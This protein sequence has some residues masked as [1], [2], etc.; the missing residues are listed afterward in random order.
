MAQKTNYFMSQLGKGSTHNI[1]RL[2]FVL[3]LGITG[4]WAVLAY[5]SSAYNQDTGNQ[6]SEVAANS[7]LL[8]SGGLDTLAQSTGQ[9]ERLEAEIISFRPYGFEPAEITRQHGRFLLAV[10]N[11]S[12][13]P[14]VEFQ[15]HRL[16]GEKLR[17]LRMT[18]GR[19]KLNDLIDLPPGEYVLTEA[20]H[21]DRTCKITITPR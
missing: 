11:R 20:N 8:A 10:L 16:A 21:P 15:L 17:Q 19:S 18:R 1:Y 5:A 13:S 2:L 9:P 14:E 4:A 6:T 12:D 7:S 3:A